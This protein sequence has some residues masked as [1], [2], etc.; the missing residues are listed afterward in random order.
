M[1]N[2]SKWI[3]DYIKNINIEKIEWIKL[4]ADELYLFLEQNYLDKNGWEYVYDK[5]ATNLYPT[6]L[7]MNYLNFD[8]PINNKNYSYL[9][10][11]VDNN[12]GKKTV[13]CATMYIDEYF[14]FEDQKI[15]VTYISSMEVNSYFRNKGVY[16]KMCEAL[17][18]FIN[19]NQHIVATKQSKMGAKYNVFKVLK[20]ILILNGFE[21]DIF[22]DNHGMIN[23]ELHDKICSKIR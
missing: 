23:S 11:V 4:N 15:P 13:V 2:K 8:N 21:N 1:G 10:G 12:I 14:M 7:G 18:N 9:L 3:N 19:P 16:K 20:D 5:H 22:E 6:L 17:T